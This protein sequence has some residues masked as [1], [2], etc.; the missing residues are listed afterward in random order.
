MSVNK[1]AL[2]LAQDKTLREFLGKARNR[3]LF[4]RITSVA[5]FSAIRS[6]PPE[7]VMLP[8]HALIQ[9]FFEN[10]ALLDIPLATVYGPGR[11]DR[12]WE[13]SGSR[14]A[15]PRCRYPSGAAR[16]KVCARSAGCRDQVGGVG[17]SDE[18]V[19]ATHSDDTLALLSDAD[20]RSGRRWAL[21]AERYR[22]A[23]RYLRIQ[24]ARGL[25]LWVHSEDAKT[26]IPDRIDLTYWMN[27]PGHS[28]R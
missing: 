21:P 25:G 17:A 26:Q 10:H 11:L 14:D 13:P 12:V 5:V 6:T 3:R 24:A 2:T 16:S 27:L 15:A 9:F 18:V 8:A 19:M 28:R 23:R 4:P 22:A 1:H 20:A 7:K